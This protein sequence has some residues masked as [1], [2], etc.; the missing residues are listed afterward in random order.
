M[1]V[2]IK[3]AATILRYHPL[4]ARQHEAVKAFMQGNDVLQTKHVEDI[5]ESSSWSIEI[6][7]RRHRCHVTFT[8]AWQKRYASTLAKCENLLI[9]HR[10]DGNF[11]LCAVLH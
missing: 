8:S 6:L 11:M 7:H 3:T 4:K 1:D 10:R 2:A 9:G 5:L